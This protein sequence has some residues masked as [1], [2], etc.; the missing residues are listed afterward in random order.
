MKK[1]IIGFIIGLGAAIFV[2]VM[3]ETLIDSKSVSYTNNN[4]TATTVSGA[5]DELFSAIEISN[6]IGDMTKISN[7]GDG[8]IASAISDISNAVSELDNNMFD[9]KTNLSQLVKTKT[10]YNVTLGD[11]VFTTDLKI[12][13]CVVL[14]ASNTVWHALNTW[15]NPNGYWAVLG[16]GN[17]NVGNITV[18]Y[19]EC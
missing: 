11:G 14:T 19:I 2:N 12:A 10:Y 1:I 9:I 17:A 18:Y 15:G 4:M 8:T 7:I 16:A 5:L 3:A 6:Q 13:D